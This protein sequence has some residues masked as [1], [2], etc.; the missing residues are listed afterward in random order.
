[1]SVATPPSMFRTP[2]GQAR[3]FAA[4]DATLA[5]W[6]VPVEAC[7]VPTRFG[8]THVLACGP[9]DAPPLVLLPGQA[10]SATMWYPNIGRLSQAHRVY[11]PDII[12]DMGKSVC[13]RRLAQP[14]DFAEW[15]TD[16]LDGLQVARAHVAGLSY[17]GFIALR[18][19][20][21]APQ[22]VR[23]LVLM[24][25]ASLLAL[26]PQFFLRMAAVFLPGFILSAQAKQKLLLGVYS[27]N[28]A[29]ALRQ[30]F[31]PN[32]F[33]YSMYLPPV[34]TEAEL[35]QLQVPTLL[36]LGD[37]E[38]IYNYRAALRRA[39]RLIPRLETALIPGAGHALNFDQPELVTERLLGFLAADDAR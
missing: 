23:R 7:D 2:A 20:L 33:R 18:L 9:R 14:A 16:L 31:T 1:M 28:T 19:A 27:A 10:I 5:L 12:G 17:G 6:P 30:L 15:L 8:R 4:Y 26:R 38:V 32:D 39:T 29:P 13:E 37:R 3:Y 24:S 35:R 36:L 21:A 11:A 25:P 22:R 34:C